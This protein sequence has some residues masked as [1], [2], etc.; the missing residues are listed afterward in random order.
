MADKMRFEPVKPVR[1]Y[2]RVVEQI[3]QAILDGSAKPGDHLPSERELMVQ[4]EVSRS[5]IRE[6]IRVLESYGLVRSRAGDPR[7][8]TILAISSAPLLKSLTRLA[9]TP[10]MSLSELLEFRIILEGTSA[11][12]AAENRTEQQ[13]TKMESALANLRESVN[14]DFNEFS[15]CDLAFHEAMAEASH[16]TLITICCE[17]VR[18]VTLDLIFGSVSQSEAP[19]QLMRDWVKLHSDVFEAIRDRDGDT[20]SSLM[21]RDIFD[22]YSSYVSEDAR[23]R[24]RR[25]I[26]STSAIPNRG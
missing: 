14:G 5:T 26:E 23:E 16:N 9:S 3:E 11:F 19:N 17:V 8:P 13:L 20:A 6:A 10:G 12:L 15:A 1:A 4:F 25:L 2:E 22:Y 18:S 24:L 7:G 21:R